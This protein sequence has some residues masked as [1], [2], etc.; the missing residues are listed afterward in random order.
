MGEEIAGFLDDSD[1][2]LHLLHIQVRVS[3]YQTYLS[4]CMP[5]CH[6]QEKTFAYH[7]FEP[8]QLP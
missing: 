1:E 2:T 8:V 6:K 4:G 7:P 5:I 3:K